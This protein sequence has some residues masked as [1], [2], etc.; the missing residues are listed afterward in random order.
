MTTEAPE[1]PVT[2]GSTVTNEFVDV[3]VKML[4]EKINKANELAGNAE[5]VA[6]SSKRVFELRDDPETD[7]PT[8]KKFQQWFE[9]ANAA[10]LQKQD[11]IEKY[12]RENK[13]QEDGAEPFDEEA[14]AEAYKVLTKTIKA[15]SD[16]IALLNGG[17][18]PDGLPELKSLAGVRRNSN[19]SGQS[20][21]KRPRFDAVSYRVAGT[22]EYVKATMPKANGEGV[23][24]NLTAAAMLI[25]KAAGAKVTAAQLQESLTE[26]LKA[27]HGGKEVSDLAG[28]E[29]T[30]V[31]LVGDKNFELQVIPAER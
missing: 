13:L 22:D 2:T 10:I 9:K 6:N 18:L 7:D 4:A 19:T 5:R 27:N 3:A 31:K 15:T 11:E 25:T 23:T 30:F 28:K 8:I 14:N 24:S 26:E 12:I 1:A 17:S 21:I 29:I 16:T 20:G